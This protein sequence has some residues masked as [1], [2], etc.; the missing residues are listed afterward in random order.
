MKKKNLKSLN[1]NKKT[2]SHFK[3]EEIKGGV[4]PL[5]PGITKEITDAIS[6]LF[7]EEEE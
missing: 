3:Q 1:L 5:T 2:I 4:T 7:C 6:D